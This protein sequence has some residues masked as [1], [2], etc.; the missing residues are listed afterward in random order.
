MERLARRP[1]RP[2]LQTADRAE[3]VR[4][5]FC[6]R[7]PLYQEAAHFTVDTSALNHEQVAHKIRV[8]LAQRSE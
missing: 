6:E 4:K 3:I 1:N 5:L 8:V 7:E 2:L